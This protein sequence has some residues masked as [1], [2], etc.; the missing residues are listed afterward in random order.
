[1]EIIPT[2]FEGLL[3]IEPRV[4]R[5]SRGTFVETWNKE[6]FAA[7][8]LFHR[9]VQDNQSVS[10]RDVLRGLHVQLPP[11][12]QGKLVRVVHGSVLDIALDLRKDQPTFGR[13]Y[14]L[15]LS[16]AGNRLLYIPPGFAHGFRSLEHG[17][18]FSY[19]CTAAYHGPSDR[20]IRW[21]DPALGIDWGTEDPHLSD[22]DRNAPLFKDFDNPF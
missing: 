7:A 4:F 14:S 18:V 19:K 9:Y 21:N 1:M 3:L 8:G 11:H 16:A 20:V 13:H 17:T 10:A 5:D 22:K 15:V 6:A 12:Q 2:P